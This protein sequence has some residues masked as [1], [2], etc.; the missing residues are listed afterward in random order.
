MKQIIVMLCA[1]AAFVFAVTSVHAATLRPRAEVAGAQVT[2]G[3]LF[4]GLDPRQASIAIARAPAPGREVLL[5]A[6]WID[7]L[8]RAYRITWENSAGQRQIVQIGRAHV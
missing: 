4:D 6:A 7:R 8:V 1:A 5:D 2:L 3:D